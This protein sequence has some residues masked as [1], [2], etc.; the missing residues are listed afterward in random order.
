MDDRT[1]P[2]VHVRHNLEGLTTIFPPAYLLSF[3]NND[4]TEPLDNPPDLQLFTRSRMP[5]ILGLNYR[6]RDLT[7]DDRTG[8][9]Q[10]I[11]TWKTIRDTLRDAS[12]TL[13]TG[14]AQATD[15][16][17]WDSLEELAPASGSVIIFAFQ[18]DPGVARTVVRPNGLQSATT[19]A[20]T[21][22]DGTSIGSA[23]G[24]DLMTDG[25]EINNSPTSQAHVLWLQP[26]L[27]GQAAGTV[28][29]RQRR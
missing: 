11:A 12:G 15:G 20:A 27:A 10:E 2:A 28:P 9:S 25:I 5:G 8:L 21:T 3:V 18:N 19:Y 6:A 22:V 1:G 7:S 24:A 14:Q 13:L 29:R 16:P 23:T 4:A 17:S 26:Q